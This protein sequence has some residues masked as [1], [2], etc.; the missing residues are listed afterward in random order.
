MKQTSTTIPNFYF[1][2]HS[3]RK[4][5]AQIFQ[6]A[7]SFFTDNFTKLRKH[8]DN[9]IINVQLGLDLDQA[10]L[11]VTEFLAAMT[12]T[13]DEQVEMSVFDEPEDAGSG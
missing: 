7:R 10:L 6:K 4:T 5:S 2:C 3:E 12:L 11:R 9:P 13:N 1:S 8:S